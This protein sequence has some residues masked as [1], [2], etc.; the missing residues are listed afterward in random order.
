MAMQSSSRATINSFFTKI[1]GFKQNDGIL[2]IGA[3]NHYDA[4]DLAAVRPV[5]PDES[6]S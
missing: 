4:L 1:D 2:V 3:T 5:Q 6:D